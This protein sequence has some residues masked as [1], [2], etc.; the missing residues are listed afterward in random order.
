MAG[1]PGFEPGFSRSKRDVLPLDEAP[2]ENVVGSEGAR[3]NEAAIGC[4]ATYVQ[5]SL[6]Q[7]R[8]PALP[9]AHIH[10]LRL[11]YEPVANRKW[12]TVKDSNLQPAG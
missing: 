4:R 11:S 12:W 2:I 6:P 3:M 7:I 5:S 8:S 10:A 1:A 9:L